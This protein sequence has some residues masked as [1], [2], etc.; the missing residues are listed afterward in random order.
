MP[1]N[2]QLAR[3][4]LEVRYTRGF[5]FWDRCG[6]ISKTICE[7]LPD[8]D[9]DS[10]SPAEVKLV[11]TKYTVNL[12]FSLDKI[13]VSC[14]LRFTP[15]TYLAEVCDVVFPLILTET[16]IKTLSRVGNRIFFEHKTESDNQSRKIIDDLAV[17][18]GIG[19]N[20]LKDTGDS[21]LENKSVEGFSVRFADEKV[22][23]QLSLMATV[24]KLEPSIKLPEA[25]RKKLP[26]PEHAVTVDVDI[27]TR[28]PLDVALWIPQDYMRSNVKMVE[29]RIL[30][31]LKRKSY[32]QSS[33][34]A[35]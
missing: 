20:L 16:E 30:P 6:R 3:Q 14:D 4:V 24:T 31:K 5:V 15:S 2:W 10:A 9:V 8:F 25:T 21:R 34:N 13:N 19:V 29:T 28:Q 18:S 17:T 7:R 11:G 23:I 22:G 26:P 27:F 33:R 1:L 35:V 12:A 32:E